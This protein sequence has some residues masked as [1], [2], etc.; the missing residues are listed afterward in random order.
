[1]SERRLVG[2][3]FCPKQSL[4]IYSVCATGGVTR[5]VQTLLKLTPY[6]KWIFLRCQDCKIYSIVKRSCKSKQQQQKP[7]LKTGKS[8]G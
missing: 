6:L 1:M 2:V 3:R 7:Y 5:A 4:K 8:Q